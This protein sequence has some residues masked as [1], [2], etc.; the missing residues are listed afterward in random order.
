MA[1]NGEELLRANRAKEAWRTGEGAQ[2]TTSPVH[3]TRK[4]TS[5]AQLANSACTLQMTVFYK[6]KF[7]D[8]NYL[9]EV[10]EHVKFEESG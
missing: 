3:P 10:M 5:M 4:V 8:F 6:C 1:D 7:P 9:L 2:C